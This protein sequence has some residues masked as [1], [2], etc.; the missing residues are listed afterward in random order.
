MDISNMKYWAEMSD[1]EREHFLDVIECVMSKVSNDD[2]VDWRD[3][4]EMDAYR[5]AV[6]SQVGRSEEHLLEES[7]WFEDDLAARFHEH[8]DRGFRR[9]MTE[10][11]CARQWACRAE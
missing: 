8:C 2:Q 6:Q 11:A 9:G 5:E 3:L 4:E 7:H 1:E 10:H